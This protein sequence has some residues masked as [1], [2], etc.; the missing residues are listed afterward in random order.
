MY[1]FWGGDQKSF[2]DIKP[3]MKRRELG[4]SGHIAGD[5]QV[6]VIECVSS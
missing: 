3:F 2:R 1:G 5:I 4:M 6:S